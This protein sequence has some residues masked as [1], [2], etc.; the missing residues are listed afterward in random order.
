MTT[1][2]E[3]EEALEGMVGTH[4]CGPFLRIDWSL[5]EKCRPV[6]RAR[7]A[8]GGSATAA[9]TPHTTPPS[10]RAS[11]HFLVDGKDFTGSGRNP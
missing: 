10:S 8:R 1:R 7:L 2:E 5:T 11:A 6:L 3:A 9:S 4:A